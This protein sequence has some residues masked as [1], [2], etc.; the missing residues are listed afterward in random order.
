MLP[1]LLDRLMLPRLLDR[2]TLPR[3]LDRP[4]LPRFLDRPTLPRLL[5]RLAK[6]LEATGLP[7][8]NLHALEVTYRDSSVD[9]HID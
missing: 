1:R 6:A 5:D 7:F 3:L 8:E 9:F 2:P 4:A